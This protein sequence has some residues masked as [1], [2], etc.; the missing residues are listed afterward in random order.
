MTQTPLTQL[1]NRKLIDDAHNAGITSLAV[2]AAIDHRGQV[3]LVDGPTGCDFD[4]A[5]ELPTALVLPGQTL[6]DTLEDLISQLLGGIEQITGYLGH[7]DQL[8]LR[9]EPV[10]TFGFIL[11]ASDPAAICRHRPSGHQWVFL[12][13]Q[14]PENLTETAQTLLDALPVSLEEIAG[15]DP[16][17]PLAAPLRAWA[18]GYYCDE[19]AIELLVAQN[20]F[21]NRTPFVDRFI[22][23]ADDAMASIDWHDVITALDAGE[24]PCSG[25]EQRLLRIQASLAAGAPISLRSALTGNDT[26]CQQLIINAVRH[27]AG[28]RPP[29]RTR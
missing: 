6:I 19:A 8:D 4:W 7:H 23:H 13:D 25:G 3:L 18:R 5:Y 24:L 26:T 1:S 15:P 11:T 21:L 29:P 17:H 2:A 10:R 14:L 28:N 20:V 27:A 9:D 16:E 22:N 12:D